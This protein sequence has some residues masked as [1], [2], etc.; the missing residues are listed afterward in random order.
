MTEEELQEHH[1]KNDIQVATLLAKFD[2]FV[3]RYERES[4][5]NKDRMEE[6][7]TTIKGHDEFIR[8]IK[9]I[10]A[11]GMVA[12]GAAGLASIGIA[13]HWIWGHIKWG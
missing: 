10:Y 5:I 6:L 8:D 2:D 7:I 9:P 4:Q 13:V 11:K 3:S 1:R 12:L